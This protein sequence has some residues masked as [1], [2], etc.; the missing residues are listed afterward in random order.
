MRIVE[1]QLAAD[2]YNEDID[3]T[4]TEKFFCNNITAF[5]MLLYLR[6]I[7]FNLSLIIVFASLLP[8]V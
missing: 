3:D 4:E 2:Q 6:F 8:L 1:S 7:F 5:I